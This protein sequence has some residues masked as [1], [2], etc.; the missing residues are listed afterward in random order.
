MKEKSNEIMGTQSV[1]IDTGVLSVVRNIKEVIGIPI[2]RF[3][4]DA[5]VEKFDRLSKVQKEKIGLFEKSKN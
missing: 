1:K 4:E 2:Q 5:I 3:I